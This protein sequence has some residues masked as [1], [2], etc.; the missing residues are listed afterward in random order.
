MIQFF[1]DEDSYNSINASL[2]VNKPEMLLAILKFSLQY[3]LPNSGLQ[4]LCKMI[5]CFFNSNIL[6]DT[7]YR[8]DKLL[9]SNDSVEYHAVCSKCQLYIKQFQRSEQTVQC[10]VCNNN[11][12]LK[13]NNANFFVVLN[14]KDKI[15]NILEENSEY[16]SNVINNRVADDQRKDILDGKKYE[17]FV[18]SLPLSERNSYITC[19]FN[20]DA[21]FQKF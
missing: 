1:N 8:I 14:V 17:L 10:H 20:S 9:C 16:Y 12:P 13:G 7:R 19:T 4:D 15:K 21:T 18:R 6:P 11:I 2:V 3:S 5:N